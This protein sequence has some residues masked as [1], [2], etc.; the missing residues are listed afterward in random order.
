MNKT[1][2]NSDEELWRGNVDTPKRILNLEIR[3]NCESQLGENNFI[4][5]FQKEVIQ[6]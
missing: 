6:L 3:M 5:I 4:L 1:Y 2:L